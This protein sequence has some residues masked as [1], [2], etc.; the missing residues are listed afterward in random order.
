MD[1]LTHTLTGIVLAR[2]GLSARYGRGTTLLLALASNVPDT[3]AVLIFGGR[4][5]APS[6][7]TLTHSVVGAP[8]LALLLAWA[9]KR[10]CP[11]MPFRTRALLALLGAGLHV[12]MDLL[13]SYG[14]ELLYPFSRARHEL[15]WT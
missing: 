8:I 6:R 13:N 9:L 4:N 12:F 2:S 7:R 14:V 15:A 3:D 5:F 11:D 10:A 1:N